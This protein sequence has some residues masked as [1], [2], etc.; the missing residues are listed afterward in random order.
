MGY[1]QKCQDKITILIPVIRQGKHNA[2]VITKPGQGLVSEEQT[3]GF[4]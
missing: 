3:G 4:A 2:P 1:T